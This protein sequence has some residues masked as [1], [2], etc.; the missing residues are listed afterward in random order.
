MIYW[1]EEEREWIK[2]GYVDKLYLM[3]RVWFLKQMS[4][5]LEHYSLYKTFLL[6]C[7]L[8]SSIHLVRFSSPPPPSSHASSYHFLIIP[9]CLLLIDL[10]RLY[11]ST[12]SY[13]ALWPPVISN[14]P[15]SF[16]NLGRANDKRT[17]H[18]CCQKW[19]KRRNMQ[20]PRSFKQASNLDVKLKYDRKQ[21][22][23]SSRVF[24]LTS[25]DRSL[26]CLMEKLM[27]IL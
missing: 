7:H 6:R 5:I 26:T 2:T 14:F 9:Q 1:G 24:F 4:W 12:N 21:T 27:H 17:T 23:I 8:S 15:Q 20:I 3:A 19:S 10:S 11:M 25:V 22:N 13:T 18:Q 16:T